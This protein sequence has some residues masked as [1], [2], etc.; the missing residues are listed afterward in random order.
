MCFGCGVFIKVLVKLLMLLLF[1]EE[2]GLM[3]GKVFKWV[4]GLL[5]GFVVLV[6]FLG[7]R[8]VDLKVV[9]CEKVECLKVFMLSMGYSI[10]GY[11]DK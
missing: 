8:L 2:C 11:V 4:G 5:V 1:V 6:L 9:E 3:V 7:M 10:V